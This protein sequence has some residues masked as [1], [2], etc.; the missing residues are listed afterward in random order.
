MRHTLDTID[1][2]AGEVVSGVGL[3]LGAGAQVGGLVVSVVWYGVV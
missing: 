2:G 1:D 3:E